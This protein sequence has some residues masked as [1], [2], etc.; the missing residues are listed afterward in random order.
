MSEFRSY[1]QRVAKKPHVC[2][3]CGGTIRAGGEYIA[4]SAR[5]NGR[6]QSGQRHIHCDAVLFAYNRATGHEAD[7]APTNDIIDW[8]RKE[9]CA[10]C[11]T[12]LQCMSNAMI[13]EKERG[14]AFSVFSCKNALVEVLPITIGRAALASIN[15]ME[16]GV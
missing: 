12:F 15:F 5:I 10:E 14:A 1:I 6:Y 3:V 4:T 7:F 11:P 8:L 9:A 16:Y 13:E 2:D